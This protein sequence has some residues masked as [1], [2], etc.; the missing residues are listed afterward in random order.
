MNNDFNYAPGVHRYIIVI[1]DGKKIH[2]CHK[3]KKIIYILKYT[4]YI[5]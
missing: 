1:V 4:F 3:F 2:T 5:F